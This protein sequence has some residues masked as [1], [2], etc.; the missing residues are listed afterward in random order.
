MRGLL[1]H[2]LLTLRLNRR[3]P[4]ALVYGYLVPV[5]FLLAFGSVFRSGSPPLL[6]EM[7]QLL[8]ISTLGGACF[9]MPTALVAE[10][11]RGL[12][13]RYRLLPVSIGALVGSTMLARFVIV[14]SAGIMQIVLARAIYTTP[15]PAHPMQLLIV[16]TFVAFAFLGLG[17]V[18]AALADNVP[19]VQALG[20]A[21]FL[22]MIMIGGVGVPLRVL[23]HWAQQ[24]AGFFPGRYAVEA[25]Q[26]CFNGNGLS[27][28]GFDLIALAVIGAA[29]CVAGAKLFR[30]DAGRHVSRA[31]SA[32]V[33][34]ALCAWIA[35]G[36]SAKTTG[37]LKPV[38]NLAGPLAGESYEAVTDAQINAI[39]YDDLPADDD[40]VTPLV[41]LG[42][43]V[44][45]DDLER[46]VDFK[47]KLDAWPPA[48]VDSATQRVRNL[49]S[50]A[51]VADATQ[52]PLEGQI[53]RAVFDRLQAD[54]EKDQLVHMLAWIILNPQDGTVITEARELELDGRVNAD[55]VRVRDGM[56]A[57]K[58]LGRLLGKIPD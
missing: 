24:V 42:E 12:W 28:A 53:A 19:A 23:P 3:S 46:L 7:G 33:A 36:F 22:P 9:G 43:R 51:A 45:G 49:L 26:P 6:R 14:A 2:F 54:F 48:H 30:W 8:T 20:Q 17:L 37:R 56:Y 31:S 27:G 29:A 50:A 38:A 4:Q 16:F 55:T 21:V 25:T 40:T 35:V 11:E 10:R 47:N 39:G 52:D 5:F 32:W 57:R 44:T 13:R 41:K 58:Y 15:M 1:R 18:I 34:V